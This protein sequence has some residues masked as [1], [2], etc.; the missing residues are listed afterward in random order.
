M[1]NDMNDE[2]ILVARL[3][4]ATLFLDLRLEKAEG[5]FGWKSQMVRENIVFLFAAVSGIGWITSQCS[6]TL[7]SSNR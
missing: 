2:V 4:L 6:T 5:L 1:I 7:P 3:F